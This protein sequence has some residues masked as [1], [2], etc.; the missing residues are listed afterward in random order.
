LRDILDSAEETMRVWR[1]NGYFDAIETYYDQVLVVGATEIFDLRCEYQ[2]P[3]LAAA[4]TTFCG[5]IA[6]Q[7]GQRSRE[8]MRHELSVRDSEPLVLVTPGG[9]EDGHTLISTYLAGLQTMPAKRR[10]RTHIVCGPEMDATQRASIKRVAAALPGVSLQDF[11]DD[12]MSLM[13]ACDVVVAMGGYN[14][15]CELLTL[16]KRAVIVPRIKP[17]LEQC[18]RTERMSALGLLSILHPNHLTPTALLDA[19]QAELAAVASATTH[20][21]LKSLDGLNHTTAA[22]FALIGLPPVA[23]AAPPKSYGVQYR[24]HQRNK[25]SNVRTPWYRQALPSAPSA[26]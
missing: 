15:V 1:K 25:Q 14:T 8:D 24:P 19:I 4:K 13:A 26:C 2:F 22:I 17:S 3:P 20:P 7:A 6:R 23:H 21:H 9:G 10:P 12:M 18:I 11:S 5:Y 16:H